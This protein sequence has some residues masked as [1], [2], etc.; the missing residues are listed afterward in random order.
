[1]RRSTHRQC[2]G[3][4]D[5]RGSQDAINSARTASSF[6]CTGNRV[7]TGAADTDAYIAI[8]GPHLAIVEEHLRTIV[9][10]QPGIGEVPP[11]PRRDGVAPFF[12]RW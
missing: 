10:A 12:S 6:G 9:H 5:V 8:P 1:M 11:R 4:T 3:S 7:Y 2:P